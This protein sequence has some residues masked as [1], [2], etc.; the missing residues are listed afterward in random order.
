MKIEI[1][2]SARGDLAE[3]FAFYE[4]QQRGLGTYFLNSLFADIDSLTIHAGVHHRVLGAYRLLG[5]V[6][7]FA[8]YYDVL[9]DVAKVKAVLDCRR[10]PKTIE[11]R[12]RRIG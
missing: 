7:P 12:L 6:F 2:P 5:R 9:N 8:V 3:G 10:D 4:K 11:K 1:L